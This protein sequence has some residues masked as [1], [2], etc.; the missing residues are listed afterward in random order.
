MKGSSELVSR[1]TL[2]ALARHLSADTMSGKILAPPYSVSP[3]LQQET[4]VLPDVDS[5]GHPSRRNDEWSGKPVLPLHV[6]R[7]SSVLK[8]AD[9]EKGKVLA[10]GLGGFCKEV[11]P[12]RMPSAALQCFR[13]PCV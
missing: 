10:I 6:Q 9:N 8:D 3:I 7:I 1:V 4:Q 13:F 11:L 2:N 5:T 12:R